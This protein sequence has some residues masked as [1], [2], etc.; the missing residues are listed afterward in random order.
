[1]TESRCRSRM[2]VISDTELGPPSLRDVRCWCGW[3]IPSAPCGCLSGFSCD[4]AVVTADVVR[5][6]ELCSGRHGESQSTNDGRI[7]GGAAARCRRNLD[8]V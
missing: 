1:M 8:S 6:G 2:D 5:L 3:R 4:M 7:A